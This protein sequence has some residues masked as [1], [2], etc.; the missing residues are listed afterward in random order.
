MT[1]ELGLYADWTKPFYLKRKN[2]PRKKKSTQLYA[3]LFINQA[4]QQLCGTCGQ[5]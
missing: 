5:S 2:Q 4:L 1:L 3:D